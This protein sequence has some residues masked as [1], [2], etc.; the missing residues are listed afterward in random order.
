MKSIAV[1][2]TVFAFTL[3]ELII[4]GVLGAIILAAIVVLI[5]RL[6]SGGGAT[7]GTAA[8][9]AALAALQDLQNLITRIKAQG[10][11][12]A[13][14]CQQLRDK[15]AAARSAGV[16]DLTLATAQKQIDELCP[17]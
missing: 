15:L 2:P 3:I 13:S 6:K 12:S 1:P 14:D 16:G 7:P 4:I 8:D 9:A 11:A 17:G 5:A 10:S